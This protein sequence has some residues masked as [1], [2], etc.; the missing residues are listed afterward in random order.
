MD[1][2]RGASVEN[3]SYMPTR[4]IEERECKGGCQS[5]TVEVVAIMSCAMG[6]VCRWNT[7]QMEGIFIHHDL[8]AC[9]EGVSE[10]AE[11]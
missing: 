7:L 10:E 8:C 6:N 5:C 4:L 1:D 3:N 9:M 11:N 2:C